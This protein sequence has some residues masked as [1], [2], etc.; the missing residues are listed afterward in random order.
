MYS[1]RRFSAILILAVF[2]IFVP[3]SIR[4]SSALAIPLVPILIVGAAALTGMALLNGAVLHRK[5]TPT[6]DDIKGAV[7]AGVASIKLRYDMVKTFYDYIG[8]AMYGKP[9][10]LDINPQ[11]FWDYVKNHL[12]E[13]PALAG[14]YNAH[15]APAFPPGV[16]YSTTFLSANT[17]TNGAA[18]TVSY[19]F[20]S[21]GQNCDGTLYPIGAVSVPPYTT[22]YNNVLFTVKKFLNGV[23]AWSHIWGPNGA[24]MTTT[25][26]VIADASTCPG[27]VS[28]PSVDDIPAMTLELNANPA[29]YPEAASVVDA[30]PDIVDSAPPAFLPTELV[31]MTNAANYHFA[32][33]LAKQLENQALLDPTNLLLQKQAADARAAADALGLIDAAPPVAPPAAGTVPAPSPTIPPGAFPSATSVIA[34][35]FSPLVAAYSGLLQHPPFTLFDSLKSYFNVFIASPEPP[36]FTMNT[37]FGGTFHFDLS[38]CNTLAA[39]VR[40]IMLFFFSGACYFAILRRW[41]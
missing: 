36:S 19:A 38:C 30:A 23:E 18:W 9:V 21:I 29:L 32:D 5:M 12:P 37:G 31:A 17:I 34:I 2:L 3:G 13:F 7:N 20:A 6:A 26:S 4:P 40:A 41:S 22:Y 8:S 24:G 27:V 25:I 15:K 14:I 35:D 10:D 16:S 11:K 28:P 1:F 33:L 39:V